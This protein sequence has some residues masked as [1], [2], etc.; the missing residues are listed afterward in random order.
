MRTGKTSTWW[1]MSGQTTTKTKH[2]ILR[3]YFGVWL[4]IWGAQKW[5]ARDWYVMDLCAGRGA[6]SDNDQIVSGS[7]LIF[8]EMI[9]E[10]R[11]KLT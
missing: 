2:E 5:T 9:D 4:T 1:D 3:K 8:L 7:P 10:K 6:Y 11:D